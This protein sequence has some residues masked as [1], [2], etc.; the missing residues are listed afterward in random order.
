MIAILAIGLILVP[1]VVM[2][3]AANT[4]A[5]D[6]CYITDFNKAIKLQ[7]EIPGVTIDQGDAHY[8]KNLGC[9]I[10]GVYRYFIG[11][12]G[13][14]STVFVMYGGIRYVIS[15]GNP[16]QIQGAKDTIAS[17]LVGLVLAVGSYSILY[18]IN[19]NLTRFDAISADPIPAA[20]SGEIVR[21]CDFSKTTDR[22]PGGSPVHCGQK[23][24]ISEASDDPEAEQFYC[25][26][27]YCPEDH[28]LCALSGQGFYDPREDPDGGYGTLPEPIYTQGRCFNSFSVLEGVEDTEE[29]NPSAEKYRLMIHPDNDFFSGGAFDFALFNEGC[30]ETLFTPN[31]GWGNDADYLF[32]TDCDDNEQCVGYSIPPVIMH[33]EGIASGYSKFG[34]ECRPLSAQ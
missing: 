8:I 32:G 21:L 17:A 28:A 33:D 16:S 2:A 1:S 24:L 13:I 27:Y 29:D 11:V 26:G 20:K 23:Q 12:A 6:P 25:M 34:V 10:V 9:Y 15:L 7:L 30:E 18:F 14:L 4:A 31:T 22:T 3:Q 19:P 5:N